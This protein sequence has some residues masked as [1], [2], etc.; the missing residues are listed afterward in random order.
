MSHGAHA[1]RCVESVR[2]LVQHYGA[3]VCAA[4][5]AAGCR[6]GAEAVHARRSGVGR[7]ASV[8][9]SPTRSRLRPA[10]DG[11]P[12]SAAWTA[13]T[14]F[15][16]ARGGVTGWGDFGGRGARRAPL[17]PP[18]SP[19]AIAA[20]SAPPPFGRAASERAS[21]AR[22]A[23]TAGWRVRAAWRPPPTG[24]CSLTRPVRR[25]P[26]SSGTP[27]PLCAAPPAPLASACLV[28]PASTP[29]RPSLKRTLNLEQLTPPLSTPTRCERL[30]PSS[31]CLSLTLS[32]RG[33]R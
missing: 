26:A 5:L 17:R 1:A 10:T 3:E 16:G 19:L 22:F 13:S 28:G 32:Q 20:L 24:R 33:H 6:P 9:R 14:R 2:A 8:R 30:K 11:R 15:G 4:E 21:V 31:P 23:D 29:R 25:P 12:R 18:P 7:V 27:A